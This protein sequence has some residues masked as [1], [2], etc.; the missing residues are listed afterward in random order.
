MDCVSRYGISV[1]AYAVSEHMMMGHHLSESI[2]LLLT[3][4]RINLSPPSFSLLLF[5]QS[6]L[7][8]F[9]FC[10]QS[11][12]VYK[13]YARILLARFVFTASILKQ[14]FCSSFSA[15]FFSRRTHTHTHTQLS[16]R[17]GVHKSIL[18]RGCESW[19]EY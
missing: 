8:I 1:H 11:F 7:I 10:R 14:F 15:L 4:P 19:S 2:Y 12:V 3:L 16:W 9:P 18:V 13:F 6:I 5:C 17:F